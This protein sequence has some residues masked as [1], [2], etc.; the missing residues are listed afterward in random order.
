MAAAPPKE[1]IMESVRV[2]SALRIMAIDPAT[3]TEIVFQAPLHV[4][5][6]ELRR[7]AA[8]KLAYVLNRQKQT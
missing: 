2:G 6:E 5:A 3:G 8:Q 7:V 1:I 4:G